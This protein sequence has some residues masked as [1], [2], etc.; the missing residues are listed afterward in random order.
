MEAVTMPLYACILRE[1]PIR[2]WGLSSRERLERILKRA[3][4]VN[5]AED[6]ESIPDESSVLL[7]RGDYLYDERVVP[8]LV[9]NTD[10]VLQVGPNGSRTAVA[11]HVSSGNAAQA[12]ELL[13]GVL[14][15]SSLAG[16]R[17]ETPDTLSSSFQ[18]RLRKSDPPFVLPITQA[19]RRYLEQRLFDWSYKGVTDLV[20]KWA[21]PR[22]AQWLTR[23]C[24]NRGITPN[25]VTFASF[26]LVVLAT[27]LFARGHYGWGLLS[28][29]MM[30]FL[31][32]VDGKLA[33]VTITSSRFGHLFD[34]VIDLVH[35]PI[36][37]VAWG[38]GLG[39]SY[40]ALP[41]LSLSIIFLLI[42]AAYVV[43]RLVE[44]AFT[45]WLGAFGLFC[46]RPVDSYFR[47]ITARRNPNL[48]LLTAGALIGQP[49]LGLLAVA[50]WTSV[51]SLF[52]I[53]RLV[54]AGFTKRANGPLHTWL[55]E[56]NEETYTKS[57]AA[58]LFARKP[59]PH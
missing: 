1:S 32:T 38:L 4:V 31:D 56:I 20:T 13:S 11:A 48:I 37:Y 45:L 3:G 58:R 25:Q 49:D 57:L 47:L 12:E 18:Q 26:M 44:L 10:V 43:G 30:T 27:V 53:V 40:L 2:L 28:G 14:G 50:I 6:L 46:W 34:H 55:L 29:W 59:A 15:Q 17:T 24:A 51:T 7:I 16:M 52:L 35:P 22:P 9:K 36:W 33:R 41:E 42:I 23:V 39:V 54:M 5:F 8:A 21:W 19:N